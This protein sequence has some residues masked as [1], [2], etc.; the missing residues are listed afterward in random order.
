MQIDLI[1]SLLLCAEFTS[2]IFIDNIFECKLLFLFF[3]ESTQ[4]FVKVLCQI[5]HAIY[6]PKK[7][8]ST[9]LH[10]TLQIDSPLLDPYSLEI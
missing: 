2:L 9:D 6:D 10:Q 7:Y 8:V 3:R 5:W 4:H 1:L